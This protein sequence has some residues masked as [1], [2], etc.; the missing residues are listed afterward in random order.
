M[1][2]NSNHNMIISWMLF[3]F[4]I[5]AHSACTQNPAL[6]DIKRDVP[7][8]TYTLQYDD[9]SVKTLETIV[10]PYAEE[11]ITTL[12][13]GTTCTHPATLYSNFLNGWVPGTDKVAPSNIP[14]I[15]I[16]IETTAIGF[17]NT[18][19]QGN[20]NSSE[21]KG[22]FMLKSPSW[23]VSIIKTG[24]V[25]T[26]GT[27]KSGWLANIYQKNPAP[28]NTHNFIISTLSIPVGSI[29][30]NALSCSLKSGSAI[31]I[32]LGDWYDTQF[33]S[34]GATSKSVDVPITLTCLAG[35]NVKAK[36]TSSNGYEDAATGKLALSGTGKA[37]G[38]AIQLLDKNN[39]PVILNKLNNLQNAS[40]AGDYILG[41]KAR[42]IRTGNI[43]PGTANTIATVEIRYE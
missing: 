11:N 43:T 14:G 10:I 15:G 16:K 6:I 12:A 40:P 17:L 29:K 41:W 23:K 34:I 38:I 28:D 21:L 22:E 2:N 30:I 35:T 3:F 9:K 20:S 19:Y 5:K 32:P 27:L 36:V 33:N 7:S 1:L 18:S 26:S 42:Y 13:K 37:S 4:T 31:S 24:Q 39:S 25:L 8:R